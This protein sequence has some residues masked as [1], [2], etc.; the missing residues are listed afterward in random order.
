MSRPSKEKFDTF[1]NVFDNHTRRNLFELSSKGNFDE[2]TISPIKIGKEANIFSALK[3]GKKII[4]KIYRVNTCDFNRM[5]DLLKRDPRFPKLT[6]NRRK[7]ITAWASREFKNLH[8]ARDAGVS[9]PTPFL[10][11]ENIL[12]MEFIGD[13]EPSK[14]IKDLRPENKKFLEQVITNMRKLHKGKLVHGDLSQFNILNYHNEPVFIDFSQSMETDT[15]YAKE[16]LERDIRNISN[17][18]NK[19][20]IITT[21]EYIRKKITQK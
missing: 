8:R 1:E 13:N 10:I 12:L 20:D 4:I 11:K 17:F 3:N 19:I 2:S 18:F 5:F 21:E 15:I 16:M 14:Q 7:T 6:K 9:V